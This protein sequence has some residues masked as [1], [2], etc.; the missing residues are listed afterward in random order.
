M[1]SLSL[2]EGAV[3]GGRYRVLRPLSAGAMGA[4]FV[5]EHIAT[6]KQRALKVMQPELVGDAKL[7]ERFVLE[8]QIGARI[9]SEHVVEVIDTGIDEGEGMPWL[10][11]ELLE[12][13]TLGALVR[14][15]GALGPAFVR[16]VLEQLCH[17]LG[18]AH[19]KGVVHRDLKP[20]NVFLATARRVGS[21]FTVKVLD[22][23]IAKLVSEAH[24]RFTAAMGTPLY[25]SPE[26]MAPG[27]NVA[28]PSD[29]WAIGLI[30]FQLLTGK[31]Y[32]RA[33]LAEGA[34][35]M[36]LMNEVTALPLESASERAQRLD[37]GQLVPDGFDAWFGRC[38][39][40]EPGDRWSNARAAWSPID[41]VLSRAPR[42]PYPTVAPKA[43]PTA[44]AV[45]AGAD[46]ST[47]AFLEQR[48]TPPPSEVA[49]ERAKSSLAESVG[50]ER[51]PASER[52]SDARGPS[53]GEHRPAPVRESP[54][55]GRSIS[56]ALAA[57]VAVGLLVFLILRRPPGEAPTPSASAS[58]SAVA[59]TGRLRVTGIDCRDATLEGPGATDDLA[60]AIGV[61]TCARLATDVGVDWRDKTGAPLEVHAVLARDHV[62]VTSTLGGRAGRGEGPTP[63]EAMVAS[64]SALARELEAPPPTDE[65]IR[66]WGAKDG[67]SARDIER[68]W[69]KY[70]LN[71]VPDDEAALRQLIAADPDSPWAYMLLAATVVQ[72]GESRAAAIEK[73]LDRASA[74]EEKGRFPRARSRAIRG[75]LLYLRSPQD[76]K[77]ALALLQQGYA[78][79]PSDP[80]VAGIYAAVAVALHATEEGL[81][82]TDRLFEL[83]PTKSIVPL[84]N[85]VNTQEDHQLDRD[86]KYL[87]RLRQVFPE[88]AAWNNWIG[89]HIFLGRF[90][91]ARRAI[92]F[93]E[94]LGMDGPA[95]AGASLR[96]GRAWVEL[97]DRNPEAARNAV[98]ALLGDPRSSVSTSATQA[99]VSSYMLEGRIDDGSSAEL[100]EIDRQ[101]AS[102]S[103]FVGTTLVLDL[104]RV[105]R[106]LGRPP[107]DAALID[108]LERLSRERRGYTPGGEAMVLSEI[109]L[110]RGDASPADRKRLATEALEKIEAL[111]VEQ[112]GGHRTMRDAILIS[113]VP[114]LRIARGDRAAV[115]RWRETNRAPYRRRRLAA[116]DAGLALEAT[117]DTEGA[118]AAYRLS[119]DPILIEQEGFATLAAMVREAALARK[120][121]SPNEALEARLTRLLGSADPGIREAILALR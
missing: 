63:M 52:A 61:G 73:G 109:A 87:D 7:R 39:T 111:A 53:T 27:S 9:E 113:T 55:A 11:M 19:E 65:Q 116:L 41:E 106:W 26:Q 33:A 70:V 36:M 49:S 35:A 10:A 22:F 88:S 69:R 68:V 24:T 4:V 60:R 59:A 12:G 16:E 101:R 66:S 121:K 114:L 71:V 75:L 115:E 40:R 97:A 20:D 32:W 47:D 93:G 104:I 5:A 8:A 18:A 102:V 85:A 13:E 76:H 46:V 2:A 37:V 110:A 15:E 54:R 62:V 90:D 112:S 78:E 74:L 51:A 64:A 56:F 86:E 100:R 67:A 105:R 42:G 94:K 84:N 118:L 3:V 44:P 92:A 17:A 28:A 120:S 48:K 119:Q 82:V 23:G 72:G 57:L 95:T 14:R 83:A 107:P 21:P 30:A 6:K 58:V 38:V 108:W 117:G 81:S 98:N 103:E 45:D 91:D 25:M 77:D 31:P 96:L 1:A 79:A 89:H 29:V 99:F 50:V 34:S 80:E 43:E